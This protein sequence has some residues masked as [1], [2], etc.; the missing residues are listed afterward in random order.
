MECLPIYN[1][2]LSRPAKKLSPQ[3][4]ISEQDERGWTRMSEPQP[5]ESS[6]P[7][8]KGFFNGIMS[9]RDEASNAPI[10]AHVQ[11]Q[12]HEKLLE[13]IQ[14]MHKEQTAKMEKQMAQMESRLLQQIA[15][16]GHARNADVSIHGRNAHGGHAHAGP[17][18]SALLDAADVR[19]P[20]PQRH[21]AARMRSNVLTVHS[22][23]ARLPPL[24]APAPLLLRRPFP[25]LPPA[26]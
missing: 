20:Q 25:P 13:A 21:A 7:P 5:S 3:L 18:S 6:T 14:A 26:C 8:M 24:P 2:F 1:P 10:S 22:L 12:M 17:R 15:V 19:P 11:M 23:A 16:G 9:G 4:P